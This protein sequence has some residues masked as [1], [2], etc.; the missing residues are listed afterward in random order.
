MNTITKKKEHSNNEKYRN[1]ILAK[2]HNIVDPANFLAKPGT[3]YPGL[4]RCYCAVRNFVNPI[5]KSMGIAVDKNNMLTDK[6]FSIACNLVE[7]Y[8]EV[9]IYEYLKHTNWNHGW[10]TIFDYDE[11]GSR[12][13]G[14]DV[15]GEELK[16]QAKRKAFPMAV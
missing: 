8:A 7:R 1:Y 16:K 2:V 4:F 11:N 6:Q 9:A 14:V 13:C 15:M 5:L 12:M 3:M 10:Q